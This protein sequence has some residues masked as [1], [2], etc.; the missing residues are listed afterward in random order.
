MGHSAGGG[1][2][3]WPTAPMSSGLSPSSERP[4]RRGPPSR[5]VSVKDSRPSRPSS[6]PAPRTTRRPPNAAARTAASAGRESLA[7]RTGRCGRPQAARPAHVFEARAHETTPADK[8]GP[9]TATSHGPAIP[10]ESTGG[11]TSGGYAPV[12][13]RPAIARPGR[14][15]AS[16]DVAAGMAGARD[17]QPAARPRLRGRAADRA[18]RRSRPGLAD[19]EGGRVPGHRPAARRGPHRPRGHR[20]RAGPAADRV[21]GHAAGSEAAAG[22]CT[23]RSSTSAT[24]APT[25][26]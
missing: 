12:H 7:A 3:L 8:T 5:A 9:P 25:C 4:T 26:C 20:A 24:S 14:D 17:P 15:V 10:D 16:R 6:A 11:P 2:A 19:P 22:G 21:H 23:P 13:E 1:Q 18:R